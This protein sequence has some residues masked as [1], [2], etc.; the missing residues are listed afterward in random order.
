MLE[1][2]DLDKLNEGYYRNS[3]D[4]NSKR[5]LLN[6]C[7]YGKE[8][9]SFILHAYT[10]SDANKLQKYNYISPGTELTG[11]LRGN[12]ITRYRILEFNKNKNSNITITF[13]SIRGKTDFYVNFCSEKCHFNKDSLTQKLNDG[14]MLYPQQTSYQTYS[15]LINPENNLCYKNINDEKCKILLVMKCSENENDYC[16]YKMLVSISEKPILMSP[17]K[18]YYNIIPKGKEDYYEII[19]DEET[20]PSVVIVLT[21]VTGDAELTV[22]RKK[23]ISDFGIDINNS[24]LI[25]VSSNKDYIPDVIRVTPNKLGGDSIAGRYLI[26]ISSVCFSSYNLYYYTTRNKILEK[27][28]SIN[29]ITESLSEE[30]KIRK[31]INE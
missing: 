21:T 18:T 15:L 8:M 6:F 11:Y 28:I 24:K 12:E 30:K 9:T 4:D 25:G 27:K 10:L 22:Y 17:K 5:D 19:I 16:S 31:R 7:I 2:S 3:Y 29:D 1:K 13:T 23:N 20:I 14:K 26:K